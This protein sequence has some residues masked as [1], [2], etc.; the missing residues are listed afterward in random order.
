MAGLS[1]SAPAPPS[2]NKLDV[3]D[4]VRDKGRPQFDDQALG[5]YSQR[6]YTDDEIKEVLCFCR[7]AFWIFCGW[8]QIALYAT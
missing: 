1:R 5:S 3:P 2:F 6:P 7:S 4:V 8:N